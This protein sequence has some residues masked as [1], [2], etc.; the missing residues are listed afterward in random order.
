MDTGPIP[1]VLG[2]SGSSTITWHSDKQPGTYQIRVGATTC[3]NGTLL[4]TGSIDSTAIGS[5]STTIQA[6]SLASGANTLY[7]CATDSDFNVGLATA[8]ITKD[9]TP[10]TTS[11]VSWS[12]STVA[13]ENV[14]VTWN[15]SEAGTYV[16]EVNG[17]NLS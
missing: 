12:P 6:T 1:S 16:I 17:S 15:A 5:I 2:T 4:A 8:S 7:L 13:A 3:T 9:T 11:I 14:T 10:P